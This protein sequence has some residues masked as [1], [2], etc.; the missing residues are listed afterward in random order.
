VPTALTIAWAD[1]DAQEGPDVIHTDAIQGSFCDNRTITAPELEIPLGKGGLVSTS[2]F[3]YPG[4]E[5]NKC[6]RCER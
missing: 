2:I 6:R 3:V 4:Q 5:L 1:E